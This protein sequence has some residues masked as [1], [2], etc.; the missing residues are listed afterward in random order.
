MIEIIG[1]RTTACPLEYDEDFPGRPGTLKVGLYNGD[2]D[3]IEGWYMRGDC[4]RCRTAWKPLRRREDE[5]ASL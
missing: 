4:W 3:S 2:Q 1:L 5:Q